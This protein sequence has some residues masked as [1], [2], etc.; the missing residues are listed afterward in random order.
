MRASVDSSSTSSPV[1]AGLDTRSSPPAGT[2]LA[3]FAGGRYEV[4]R[5][6]REGGKK[7]VY[8]AQDTLVDRGVAFA[9]M[10]T[11]SL[12]EAGRTFAVMKKPL[13]LDGIRVVLGCVARSSETA[14][15][16]SG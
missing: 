6:L 5:F 11:E 4:K 16:G 3:S 2:E 14:M 13:T 10:E 1:G 15:S 7:R 8:P 12:D 9:L